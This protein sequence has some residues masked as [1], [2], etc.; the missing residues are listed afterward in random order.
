MQNPGDDDGR[1]E[2]SPRNETDPN[3]HHGSDDAEEDIGATASH[4]K[5]V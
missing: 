2:S 3:L 5:E 4:Y 1:E